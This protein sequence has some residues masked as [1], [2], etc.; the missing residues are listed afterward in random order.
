M[1]GVQAV[2]LR[3]HIIAGHYDARR[4]LSPATVSLYETLREIVDRAPDA[5]WPYIRDDHEQSLSDQI[6]RIAADI[7]AGGRI[8]TAIDEMLTNGRP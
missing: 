6:Q 2:D 4:C 8:P 5:R 7:G 1:F 3:T